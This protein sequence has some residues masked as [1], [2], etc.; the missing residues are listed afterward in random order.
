L[1]E[2]VTIE[3]STKPEDLAG[4]DQM[5]NFFEEH[6]FAG[7]VEVSVHVE[8]PAQDLS[9]NLKA[10]VTVCPS[11]ARFQNLLKVFDVKTGKAISK[12]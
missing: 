12:F 4:W 11:A 2:H 7:L 9:V 10:N 8:V 3:A 6:G 5:Q 1:L